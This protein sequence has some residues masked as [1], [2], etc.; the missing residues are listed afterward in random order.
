MKK[1]VLTLCLG[2]LL[3]L[4]LSACQEGFHMGHHH[5]DVV[6][7]TTESVPS[8][9]DEGEGGTGESGGGTGESGGT[10]TP[11]THTADTEWHYDESNPDAGHWHV[12]TEDGV[13]MDETSHSWSEWTDDENGSTH[14]RSCECGATETETHNVYE[15]THEDGK[16]ISKC[17]CGAVIE[18]VEYDTYIS[19][20]D[21]YTHSDICTICG[22][23]VSSEE[24]TN[25]GEKD[26]NCTVCGFSAGLEYW[27]Y[28]STTGEDSDSNP[29]SYRVHSEGDYTGKGLVLPNYYYDEDNELELPVIATYGGGSFA[30]EDGG[31][32]EYTYVSIPA[33]IEVI[34]DYD[35]ANFNCLE[36]L[37]FEEGSKLETIEEDAFVIMDTYMD[38][39]DALT[40]VTIPASVKE[41]GDYAFHG[42]GGLETLTFE[43]G[44]Q[45]ETLGMQAFC[46]CYSLKDLTI[47]ASVTSIGDRAFFQCNALETLT[48]EDGINLTKI[49][50]QTFCSCY[51]LKEVTIPKSVK[52]LSYNAF[53]DCNSLETLIFE[54]GSQLETIGYQTFCNCTSLKELTI[55][56]T[57]TSIGD[58]AFLDCESLTSLTFESGSVLE[59]I[60]EAAFDLLA[61][62]TLSIPASVTSIAAYAFGDSDTVETIVVE[63]SSDGTSQLT[64]LGAAF[65]YDTALKEITLPGSIETIEGYEWSY[66]STI[67][68]DYIFDGCESLTTIN[69]YGTEDQWNSYTGV[70][71]L[72]TGASVTYLG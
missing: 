70:G 57:V 25:K 54:E 40:D 34:G 18:S 56:A 31:P 14:S 65:A 64:T 44:T 72:P 60:G 58:L 8:E 10:E 62:T 69:F 46:Y 5:D 59:T 33:N 32:T 1:K 24:H 71:T 39:G 61:V 11:H 20:T 9:G 38:E 16:C 12:C 67:L 48:F 55:P 51:E 42:R 37:V 50:D 27:G 28:D 49:G 23:V 53:Y 45:L 7:D 15:A 41:I 29:D 30:S 2:V 36:T 66:G 26:G 35:F 43:E 21:Q 3:T 17:S 6:D 52:T 22:E 68:T 4:S 63:G 47:P 13:K 19:V